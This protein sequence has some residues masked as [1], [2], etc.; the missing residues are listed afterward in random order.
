LAGYTTLLNWKNQ[1][2]GLQSLIPW[3]AEG[4][5]EKAHDKIMASEGHIIAHS[6]SNGGFFMFSA[7]LRRDNSNPHERQLTSRISSVIFDSSPAPSLKPQT[8]ARCA[9]LPHKVATFQGSFVILMISGH[10]RAI[11]SVFTRRADGLD[12]NPLYPMALMVSTIFLKVPYIG[13]Y[14]NDLQRIWIGNGDNAV[15][16]VTPQLYLYSSADNL[17]EA[18]DIRAFAEHQVRSRIG[19][20]LHYMSQVGKTRPTFRTLKTVASAEGTRMH[21]EDDPMGKLCACTALSTTSRWLR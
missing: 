4:F 6:F 19:S 12:C 21:C 8:L 15:A 20:A 3:L 13:S 11:V 16:P 7:V 9:L 1:Y 18:A 17:I 10:C 5:A 14:V 2:L